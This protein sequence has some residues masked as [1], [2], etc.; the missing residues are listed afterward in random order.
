MGQHEKSAEAFREAL[1]VNPDNA[2]A[3]INLGAQYDKLGR[4]DDAIKY[5]VKALSLYPDYAEGHYELGLIYFKAGKQAEALTSFQKA[6][7]LAPGSEAALQAD[8]YIDLLGGIMTT[9]GE[10]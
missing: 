8:K 2:I 9:L 7:E 10:E 3:M 4:T 5:Y 1:L 6:K